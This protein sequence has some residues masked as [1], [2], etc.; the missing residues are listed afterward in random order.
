MSRQH[1][2]VSSARGLWRTPDDFWGAVNAKFG[3]FDLDVDNDV[4]A[5]RVHAC[6]PHNV[7]ALAKDTEWVTEGT[8]RVWCNPPFSNVKQWMAKAEQESKRIR[9]S[10]V[11]VLAPLSASQWALRYS[12][13]A[14]QVLILVPRIEFDPPPGVDVSRNSADNMLFV[15]NDKSPYREAIWYWEWSENGRSNSEQ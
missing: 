12:K 14:S 8:R 3:P 9:G 6:L 11:C 2:K 4:N 7:D 15:F 13:L 1:P 5:S 10:T